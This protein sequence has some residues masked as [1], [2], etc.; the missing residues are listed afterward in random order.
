MYDHNPQRIEAR[1]VPSCLTSGL[2]CGTRTAEKPPHATYEGILRGSIMSPKPTSNSSTQAP[3]AAGALLRRGRRRQVALHSVPAL[4]RRC[5]ECRGSVQGSRSPR[6]PHGQSHLRTPGHD[7]QRRDREEAALSF[8]PGYP[9]P[10]PGQLRLQRP[11]LRM[12]EL[13]DLPRQCP[14]RDRTP[15]GADAGRGGRHGAQA[16]ARRRGLHLQRSGGV[17]R[18]RARRVRGFQGSRVCTRRSSPRPT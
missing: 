3:G 14:H 1:R 18:V 12:S 4:L 9:S 16:Q 17:D 7:H 15:A 8:P 6:R 13:A 10:L 2:D 5:R 11:L